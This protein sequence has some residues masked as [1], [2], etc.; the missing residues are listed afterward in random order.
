MEFN[1]NKWNY[2]ELVDDDIDRCLSLY[3]KSF[4]SSI[5]GAM[6]RWK[7]NN[8]KGGGF[9]ACEGED[10]IAYY[11]GIGRN[12]F[13]KDNLLKCVQI[14]DTMVDP[15][16]RGIFKKNG[17]FASTANKF[18]NS[19][20][21][22]DK[23]YKFSFGFPAQ[24][25]A[26]LGE[27]LGIYSIVDKLTQSIWQTHDKKSLFYFIT[28]LDGSEVKHFLPNIWNKMKK[29]FSGNI[30]GEKSV[31]FVEDRYIQHPLFEYKF[32]ALKSRFWYKPLSILVAREHLGDMSVE[33]LDIIGDKKAFHKSLELLLGHYGSMGFKSLFL[34][35]TPAVY[36]HLPFSE[37]SSEVCKVC[38]TNNNLSY[39]V[40]NLKDCWVMM[41]G[42]SD[43]R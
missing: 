28:T 7:Y 19:Y 39:E 27:R 33:I 14:S 38:I 17:V 40:D 12:L 22:S 6:W 34:W 1:K 9:V 37:N 3:E 42:E 16:K 29:S 8:G 21:G 4:G 23:K 13:V 35:G 43:F 2:R 18:I 20:T 25:H 10:I 26:Q 5:D 11:G 32:F 41:G 31:D 36:E 30:I 24:R 15:A